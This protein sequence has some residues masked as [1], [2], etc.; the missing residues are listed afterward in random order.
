[1]TYILL[2]NALTMAIIASG[3][4]FIL[5]YAIGRNCKSCERRKRNLAKCEHPEVWPSQEG[6]ND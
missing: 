5:G 3:I 1:M 6:I 2:H 4:G